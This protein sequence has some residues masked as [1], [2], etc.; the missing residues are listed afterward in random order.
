LRYCRGG[1]SRARSLRGFT[2]FEVSIVLVIVGLI[3]GG[4]LVGQDIIRSSEMR[5]TISQI[6]RYQAAVR[7]F[8]EKYDNQLP[9]DLNAKTATRYGFT[10]RGTYPGM[11]DGNGIIEGV[12]GAGATFNWGTVQMT[13]ETLMFWVDLT[14]ANGLKINLIDG[15]FSTAS[16]TTLSF[17]NKTGTTIDLYLPQAK[18]GRGNYV[19][20][21][22]GGVGGAVH[23]VSDGINYYAISAVYNLDHLGILDSTPGMTVRQA[24][25]I[26]KKIDD[27]LPQTGNVTAQYLQGI[28]ALT[29]PVW[30]A[31]G[32]VAGTSD[33]TA[34]AG[35]STTCYDNSGVAGIQRYSITQSNGSGLNCALSFQFQ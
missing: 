10:A 25:D 6:Q 29:G 1:S 26:D 33:T 32:G 7:A 17:V 28:I 5:G 8:E 27:G 19:Y 12:N 35:S 13:G 2:L 14:S 18:M 4:V 23:G 3:I 21:W 22:S 24:Y 31:G 20:V 30:A 11:G 34:T 9:G 15:S 16:P